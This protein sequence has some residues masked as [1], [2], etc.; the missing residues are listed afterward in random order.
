MHPP[1][2]GLGPWGFPLVCTGWT[3][4]AKK[5][6]PPHSHSWS[7]GR[8]GAGPACLGELVGVSLGELRAVLL[9]LNHRSSCGQSRGSRAHCPV[10]SPRASRPSSGSGEWV[11][12]TRHLHAGTSC[13]GIAACQDGLRRKA[14]SL[15]TDSILPGWRHFVLGR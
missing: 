15:C 14:Y 11:C 12:G 8:V 3:S 9:E 13:F 2:A 5:D 10:P 4:L 1:G 6:P 7:P